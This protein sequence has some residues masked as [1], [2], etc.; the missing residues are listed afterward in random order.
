M[1]HRVK[2]KSRLVNCNVSILTVLFTFSDM[3]ARSGSFTIGER[4]PS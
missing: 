3:K 4:V 1:S 2:Y